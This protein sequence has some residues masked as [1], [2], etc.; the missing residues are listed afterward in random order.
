MKT[1]INIKTDKEVKDRAQQI[2]QEIGLPLS[3]VIN[4]YLKEFVRN[5][6]VTFSIEP[7]LRPEI[8][9]MLKQA[10]RDYRAGKNISG[11]FATGQEMDAYLA[12]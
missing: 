12:K 10:S 1:L 3:T 6:T 2:A 11:P 8:E 7:K 5:R 4:A 9:K